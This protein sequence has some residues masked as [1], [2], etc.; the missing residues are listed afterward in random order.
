MEDAEKIANRVIKE[1]L[2]WG[3]ISQ[4][5]KL[6]IRKSNIAEKRKKNIEVSRELIEK[7]YYLS[8]LCIYEKDS[9]ILKKALEDAD[10]KI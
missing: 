7:A 5:H 2:L 10:G 9:K 8:E 3:K 6:F 1:K 4:I